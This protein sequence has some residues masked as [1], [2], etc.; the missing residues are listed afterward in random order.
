VSAA[1]IV[2]EVGM[3]LMK[4]RDKKYYHD[5]WGW[6]RGLMPTAGNAGI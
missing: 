3:A 4:I 5:V 6:V 1:K 2:Y